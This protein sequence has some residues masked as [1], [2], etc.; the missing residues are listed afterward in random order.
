MQ[1]H[2]LGRID[3]EALKQFGIAQ[4]QLDHLAQLVDRRGHAADIIVRHIGAAQFARLLE[5]V[6]QLDLGLGVDMDDAAR[7]RRHHGQTNLLQR[8]G[9]RAQM[10]EH[11]GWHVRHA[12]LSDGRNGV[13]LA[14]RTA[15]KCAAERV[16]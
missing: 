4:R 13:A 12:L 3:A 8:I 1:Q 16:A 9:G 6:A 2:P 14:E 11:V 10:L 7:H 5:L 15:E